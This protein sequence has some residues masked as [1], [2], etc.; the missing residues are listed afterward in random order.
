MIDNIRVASPCSADWN[1][2]PGDDRIRHCE[3]CNLNVYNLS[4]FTEHE[5]RELLLKREGRLC[6]R[7]YQRSD[8]TVMA[9][10][11]PVGL[12]TITRRISRIGG[13]L[14]SLL[15][16]SFMALPDFAQSYSST[17]VA[18]AA[19]SVQV[20]DPSGARLAE[21][22]V[23]LRETSRNQEFKG[24][25]DKKGRLILRAPIGGRYLLTVSAPGLMS[26]TQTVELRQG[27]IL[28]LPIKLDVAFMGEIVIID[29]PTPPNNIPSNTM[30][31]ISSGPQPMR[32]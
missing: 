17:N 13:V 8:G 21:A 11:C 30:P 27:K 5:I 3:A 26:Y 18:S 20:G 2:M 22:S 4:A 15:A 19:V 12:R 29:P 16:S 31:M 32:R 6:G 23:T 24:K 7:L 25:T 1:K 28:S 10:N 9:Q 14:F